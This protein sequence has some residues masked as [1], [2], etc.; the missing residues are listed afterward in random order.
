MSIT[1]V[2]LLKKVSFRVFP[3]NLPV[4]DIH[5]PP[6]LRLIG[7]GTDAI[8]VQ[9]PR[10]ISV[11]YKLFH[12]DRLWKKDNEWTSYQKLGESPYFAKCYGNEEHYLILSYE[13]GL[14][15]LE[16]LEQGVEIPEQ[17]LEDVDE[18]RAYA[19][20]VGLNPRDIHLKNVFLQEGR[21]KL[22]DISEYVIPG[23]DHRWDH[24][25]EGYRQF[26]PLIRGMK[27]PKWM[28][29][30]VKKLYLDQNGK[31]NSFSVSEFG[32]RLFRLFS[33]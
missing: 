17:V 10:D 26:Y 1:T 8:V 31:K 30:Y 6:E 9:D 24:L 29:E 12:P 32:K 22:I 18:A 27:I 5:I 23:N 20:S 7:T 21:A 11:V 33:A 16:C 25:V 15:L 19:R 4:T 2:A 13:S 28:I 14:T 3:K